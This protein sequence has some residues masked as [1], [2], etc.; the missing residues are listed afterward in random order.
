MLSVLP[1]SCG[2]TAPFPEKTTGVRAFFDF[3]D[4]PLVAVM[5][6][7]SRNAESQPT[8]FHSSHRLVLKYSPWLSVTRPGPSR[9]LLAMIEPNSP[10]AS[11]ARSQ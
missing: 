5:F 7:T 6:V 3:T 11:S 4:A 1:F 2:C 8:L 10:L 9:L